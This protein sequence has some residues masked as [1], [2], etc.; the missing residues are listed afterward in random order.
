[1]GVVQGI[2]SGDGELEWDEEYGWVRV[3]TADEKE[4]NDMV[5]PLCLEIHDRFL[6]LIV[7]AMCRY[8]LLAS[9]SMYGCREFRSCWIRIDGASP[10]LVGEDKV[11]GKRITYIHPGTCAKG[12]KAVPGRS[13]FD[14]LFT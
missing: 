1:M 5:K 13:F 7:H 9:Y 2:L 10:S 6:R 12:D 14:Y 3:E 11:D 4:T 8:Y